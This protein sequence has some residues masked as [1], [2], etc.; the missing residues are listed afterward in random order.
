MP[1]DEPCDCIN[2]TNAAFAKAGHLQIVDVTISL[3][4]GPSCAIISTSK[5]PGAKV[6]RGP[7]LI[8]TFCP[9]CGT[10]YST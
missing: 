2:R 1:V 8:A 3:S 9:F 10:K 7:I 6:K 5:T 4:G